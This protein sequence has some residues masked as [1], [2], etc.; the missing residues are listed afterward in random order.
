MV[1]NQILNKL[2]DF[3]QIRE[4]LYKNG[5]FAFR[6]TREYSNRLRFIIG[7][8]EELN[9]E[10]EVFTWDDSCVDDDYWEECFHN[11]I[12]KGSSNK[13]F[14]A[15]YDIKNPFSQNANDNSAGILSLIALKMLNPEVNVVFL[16]AEESPFCGEGAKLF[17]QWVYSTHNGY[18]GKEYRDVEYIINLDMVGI[19][20]RN[21]VISD[22]DNDLSKTIKQNFNPIVTSLPPNDSWFFK[23]RFDTVCMSTAPNI[24]GKTCFDHFKKAH[25]LEDNLDSIR[26][27]DMNEFVTEVLLP[28]TKVEM[29]KTV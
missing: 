7:L 5:D 21:I 9:I 24:K 4:P 11:L 27:D 18:N 1:T 14:S 6:T 26:I 8:L 29:I 22:F 20:G 23:R 25:T 16:D 12:I 15:H 2:Y 13:Y 10:Y 3:C 17:R 28:L 19:G